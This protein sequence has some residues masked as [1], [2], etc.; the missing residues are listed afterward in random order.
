MMLWFLVV[1]LLETTI[2]LK[3]AVVVG[4]SRGI[5]RGIAVELGK[6]QYKV[7]C[8][9]RSSKGGSLTV[10]TT[11]QQVTDC[12][13]LG[14][15]VRLDATKDEDLR[16]F[17]KRLE[18]EEIDLLAY[19][20]YQ[21]PT[22]D[23][24]T[25][26]DPFWK[27]DKS[28]WDTCHGVGLKAAYLTLCAFAEQLIDSSD[29][30]KRPL[31]VLVS[32]F[33]G[34]SYTFNLA[35]GVG[36]AALDRLAKDAAIELRAKVDVLSL[37]PGVVSTENNIELNR[38]GKWQKASGGL[39]LDKA[40]SPN[41]TG[42]AIVELLKRPDYCQKH[43]GTVQV[44]AELANIFDFDDPLLQTRP[45][46]I[47]SLRFLVPNFLL[48]DNK[49]LEDV[50]SLLRGPVTFLRDNAT[51]DYLLPWSVFASGPPPPK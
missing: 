33:G 16:A 22:T 30:K 45:P 37:Y 34:I 9:G 1:L 44:V 6:A 38:K 12:G 29:S 43:S 5:G 17:A 36:K 2:A 24:E 23:A 46:S 31:V 13:G 19:A 14:I 10:E 20:A 25:F 40:E 4:A 39:D 42:K 28:M 47:R 50:P 3:V 18:K 15:P 41:F 8:C 26:R 27:Q 11:A 21:T 32:S 51:P 35:Y 48:T 49:I 7:Y